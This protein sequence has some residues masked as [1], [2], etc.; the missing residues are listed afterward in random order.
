MNEQAKLRWQCRRGSLELDLLLKNYLETDYLTADETEK[1]RFRELLM[2]EDDEL[3]A[4][5][6]EDGGSRLKR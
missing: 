6:M 5:F 1:A 3:L 2:L 4:I